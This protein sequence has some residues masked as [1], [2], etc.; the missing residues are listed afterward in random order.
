M[1][2]T[3]SSMTGSPAAPWT[4]SDAIQAGI[5]PCETNPAS[6]LLSRTG[7]QFHGRA[8]VTVGSQKGGMR[9]VCASCALKYH[10]H[11]EQRPGVKW[12]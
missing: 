5:I 12:E 4:N 2:V 11:Q 6:G 7:D 8:V 10:R 1:N 3:G 9:H